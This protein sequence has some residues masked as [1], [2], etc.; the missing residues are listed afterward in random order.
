MQEQM[1]RED[2]HRVYPGEQVYDIVPVATPPAT[3]STTV[4]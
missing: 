2:F 3:T 1:A 4:P